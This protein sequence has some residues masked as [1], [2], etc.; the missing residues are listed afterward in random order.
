MNT[1]LQIKVQLKIEL[2]SWGLLMKVFGGRFFFDTARLVKQII[3]DRLTYSVPRRL[4]RCA[5]TNAMVTLIKLLIVSVW[6]GNVCQ[7]KYKSQ[8]N[9]LSRLSYNTI[10]TW[11]SVKL[12]TC[13]AV[14][15]N[16]TNICHACKHNLN[17]SWQEATIW[18]LNNLAIF[19]E[20]L[21]APNSESRTKHLTGN[22]KKL[23]N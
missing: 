6:R 7:P 3:N 21:R 20:E 11:L 12:Q 5:S 8:H 1:R 9:C 18:L 17:H 10:Y 23:T 22:M 16:R 19:E 4:P 14:S 15:V 13:E 2:I